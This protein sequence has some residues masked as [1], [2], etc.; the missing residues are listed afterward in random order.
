MTFKQAVSL[1]LKTAA[2]A[3]LVV[4]VAAQGYDWASESFANSAE[5]TAWGLLG[6]AIAGLIAV[7]WAFVTSPAATPVGKAA[8]QAVQVLLGLPIAGIVL[9][10]ISDFVEVGKLLVPTIVLT[11]L[12]FVVSYLSNKNP[13]PSTTSDAGGNDFLKG[14]PA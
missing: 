14:T 13:T 11:V 8:R 5:T 7:G 9:D 12:A 2:G 6:A 10:E 4:L 1:F 3:A